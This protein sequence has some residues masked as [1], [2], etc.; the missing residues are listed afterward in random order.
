MT[1]FDVLSTTDGGDDFVMH[2]G[3][4]L[5]AKAYHN[6]K[7]MFGPVIDEDTGQPYPS[8]EYDVYK[9]EKFQGT[10]TFSN[11]EQL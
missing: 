8:L 3:W 1:E 6:A 9:D 7:I 11:E 4:R 2:K 10:S 5:A